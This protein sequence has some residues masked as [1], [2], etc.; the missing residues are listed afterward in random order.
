M[1]AAQAQAVP[2]VH[3]CCTAAVDYKSCYDAVALNVH[4]YTNENGWRCGVSPSREMK[5]RAVRSAVMR[6]CSGEESELTAAIRLGRRL[7]PN[8][9]TLA[10]TLLVVNSLRSRL[11]SLHTPRRAREMRRLPLQ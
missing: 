2:C 8:P 10:L 1:Q 4:W 5:R 9:H 6:G 7:W 11:L 3:C